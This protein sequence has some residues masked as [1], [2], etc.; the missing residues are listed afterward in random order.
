MMCPDCHT[1][2]TSFAEYCKKCGADLHQAK[3]NAKRHQYK[4]LFWTF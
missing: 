4:L 3:E 1:Q 2:V